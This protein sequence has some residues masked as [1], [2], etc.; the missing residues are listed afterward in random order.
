MKN[1]IGK[2]VYG[3]AKFYSSLGLHIIPMRPKEKRPLT[4]WSKYLKRSPTAT[5]L[6]RWFKGKI[7]EKTGIAVICGINNL[8]V[9]DI[10]DIDYF[11]HFFRQS[12]EEIAKETWVCKTG[13]GYHIYFRYKGEKK[14]SQC[15]KNSRSKGK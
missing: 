13:K 5:K 1:D 4:P 10:E 6:E 15:S 11:D 8:I 3:W 12:L 9:L 14:E 2:D 7:P